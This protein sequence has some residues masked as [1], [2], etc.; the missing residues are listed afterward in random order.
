VLGLTSSIHAVF[1][2]SDDPTK[3]SLRAPPRRKWGIWQ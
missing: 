3:P 1:K 2:E